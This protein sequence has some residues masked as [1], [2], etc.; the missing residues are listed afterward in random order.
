MMY[1]MHVYRQVQFECHCLNI[2]RNITI[3]IIS[4]TDPVQ[5][6]NDLSITIA[7][8]WRSDRKVVDIYI[9]TQDNAYG[10]YWNWT[11]LPY[12][13]C[14]QRHQWN[15]NID[16]VFL[17][18]RVNSCADLFVT[19]RHPFMSTA[20]TQI[21][22]HVKDPISIC[23]KRVGLTTGGMETRKNYVLER[24]CVLLKSWVAPFY[25]CSPLSPGKA[26]WISRALHWDK[27]VI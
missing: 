9:Y 21:G 10:L 22:P 6:K 15:G 23:C 8:I 27:E 13:T 3:N 16:F 24:F 7:S 11:S 5:V 4:I 2:V 1:A 19:D 12:V 14:R 20:R 17:S 26:P 18:L 25:G